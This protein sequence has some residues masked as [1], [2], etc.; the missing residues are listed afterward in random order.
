MRAHAGLWVSCRLSEIDRVTCM[1]RV[2]V[3]VRVTFR[4]RSQEAP[5]SDPTAEQL[6]PRKAKW[7][8][9]RRMPVRN[10]LWVPSPDKC[11]GHPAALR[12]P[13]V[14]LHLRFGNDVVMFQVSCRVSVH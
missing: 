10:S 8:T 2:L 9:Q 6:S 13:S 14:H 4:V 1:L 11:V 7:N 5:D 3:R 12:N